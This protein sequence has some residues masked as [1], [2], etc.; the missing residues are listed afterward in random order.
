M[1]LSVRQHH[2][3][4]VGKFGIWKYLT[5]ISWNVEATLPGLNGNNE[6]IY[7]V[8]AHYDSVPST[9]GADDNAA[10]V[11]AVLS[12]AKILSQYEFNQTIRFVCFSGEE[13]GLL[14]S[15][16]YAKEAYNNNENLIST[17]NLDMIGYSETE[18][19]KTKIRFYA[20]SYTHLRAHET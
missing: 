19:D 20:V 4:A 10:G 15:E 7:I 5:F 17:I 9:P 6:E 18:E 2:W 13:Q 11:A 1:G 8:S 16:E 3:E 12:A 14:G